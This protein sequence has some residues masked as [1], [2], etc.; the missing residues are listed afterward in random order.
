MLQQLSLKSGLHASIRK[1]SLCKSVTGKNKRLLEYIDELLWGML[2]LISKVDP[3]VAPGT[4]VDC[5]AEA[6]RMVSP[7]RTVTRRIAYFE[8]TCRL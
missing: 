3:S 2:T 5:M 8:E 6:D 1:C 7:V 4:V